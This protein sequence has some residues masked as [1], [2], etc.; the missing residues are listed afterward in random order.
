[1]GIRGNNSFIRLNKLWGA[2]ESC[3]FVGCIILCLVR[4]KI[5]SEP[6]WTPKPVQ[7]GRR[8]VKSRA[9]GVIE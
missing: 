4:M 2:V 9:K 6:S 1:M 3:G 5:Y 8:K 7:N